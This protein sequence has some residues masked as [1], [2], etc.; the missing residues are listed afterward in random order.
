MNLEKV[1]LDGNRICSSQ[2][3]AKIL[4]K[5]PITLQGSEDLQL[6]TRMRQKKWIDIIPVEGEVKSIE[7]KKG[8]FT[9]LYLS[10]KS[11]TFKYEGCEYVIRYQNPI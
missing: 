5:L 8:K 1:I 6:R 11:V 3:L 7:F 9:P 2:D 4:E 10:E